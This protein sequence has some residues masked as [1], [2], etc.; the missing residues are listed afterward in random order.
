LIFLFRV[1]EFTGISSLPQTVRDFMID[2]TKNT[3]EYRETNDVSR[4]DFM[5]LLLQLR[6]KGK[7]GEDG[8][9]DAKNT[10]TGNL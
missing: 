8:E 9:W 6:N 2:I 4:K 10:A 1:L 5:Q 3:I 7:V